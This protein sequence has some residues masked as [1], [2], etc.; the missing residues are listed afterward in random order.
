MNAIDPTSSATRM[1][2]LRLRRVRVVVLAVT[3]GVSGYVGAQ[4]QVPS[5]IRPDQLKKLQ[6]EVK[7]PRPLPGT[8]RATQGQSQATGFATQ[9]Q[10]R[11]P[12]LS[13]PGAGSA[14]A[15]FYLKFE[16][17]DHKISRLSLLRHD[18]IAQPA[19]NDNDGNDPF[20]A[21]AMYYDV[22]GRIVT[23]STS[24]QAS[25]DIRL[26]PIRPNQTALLAGF[27]F[28]RPNRDNN[29]RQVSVRLDSARS[30]AV[31]SFV[32]DGGRE[33]IVENPGGATIQ[34]DRARAYNATVQYVV[35]EA[36][37]V[38]EFG[39]ASGMS[40]KVRSPLAGR[41]QAG[42][43]RPVDVAASAAGQRRPAQ[44]P[45]GW[46]TPQFAAPPYAL[47]GFEFRFLDSD[48]F[49]EEVGIN[50]ARSTD[51]VAF[52]D[53]QRERAFS[54]NVDYAVLRRPGE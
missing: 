34:V 35:V 28:E 46:S 4:V 38:R 17:G 12:T 36:S 51:V 15:A 40:R 11:Q 21:S 49:L 33:F 5:P 16:N 6:P 50:L 52:R 13:I 8:G 22:G 47:Q 32:D 9:G 25:C 23:K 43:G 42:G 18:G 1:R 41:A 24:C 14:L 31:V 2:L 7:V 39:R 20:T 48:H 26:D 54:W 3:L 19:I 37:R 29:V 45:Y 53:N 30:L 27:S 10:S 44:Y